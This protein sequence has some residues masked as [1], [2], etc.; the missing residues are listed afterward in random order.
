MSYLLLFAAGLAM[1]W[2]NNLAGAGGAL[3]LVALEELAGLD[4]ATANAS[5]RPAALAI[6]LSGLLGFLSK[7]LRIPGRIWALGLLTIPGA[8]AGS[9][10]AL[11]LETWVYQSSL[12]GILLLMLW[13]QGRPGSAGRPVQARHKSSIFL[14]LLLYTLIGAH[15]GFLQIAVGLVIMLSLTLTHSEDLVQVNSAKMALVII[16]SA[17]STSYLAANDSIQWSPALTLAAGAGCGSF[18]ASRWSVSRGHGA[19]RVV[20]ILICIAVLTR[21]AVQLW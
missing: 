3:G 14:L 9:W 10:M 17:T 18:L 2:I 8:L 15:M 12:A 21:L 16:S 19:V 1:G 7:G 6:G 13:Q 11:A 20:V 4:T 5:L